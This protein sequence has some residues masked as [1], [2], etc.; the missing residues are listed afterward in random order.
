MKKIFQEKGIPLKG[1]CTSAQNHIISFNNNNNK[2][3][4]S[5]GTLTPK[6]HKNSVED[7]ARMI[8]KVRQLA[9]HANVA[10]MPVLAP[11]AFFT[12]RTHEELMTA[13]TYF[14]SGE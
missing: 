7:S 14:I 10:Q 1:V 8:E 13:V 5:R 3:K 9:K 11:V 4:Y 2:K 6:R 12:S